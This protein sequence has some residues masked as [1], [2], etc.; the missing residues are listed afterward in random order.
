MSMTEPLSDGKS[1]STTDSGEESSAAI[2]QQSD[3]PSAEAGI[4]QEG[5]DRDGNGGAASDVLNSDAPEA[6]P[7]KSKASGEPSS[8]STGER[9][10]RSTRG[11][12]SSKSSSS[13]SSDGKSTSTKGDKSEGVVA[14][15]EATSPTSASDKTAD[16]APAADSG[17]AE[18]PASTTPSSGYDPTP[19]LEENEF[20]VCPPPSA[21]G[22]WDPNASAP[23]PGKAHPGDARS[24]RRKGSGGEEFVLIYRNESFLIVR[25]GQVGTLGTWT[26]IEYP[27][28]GSAAH[29]YAQKCS[30]FTDAGFRDLR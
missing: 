11:R 23:P 5:L 12:K 28:I 15:P 20:A 26:V 29:A 7:S 30:E 22:N 3:P 17:S 18:P 9:S 4:A 27:H 14:Q 8:S 16:A 2:A 21:I 10:K 13:S 24:F 1:S 19:V 6:K 25:A